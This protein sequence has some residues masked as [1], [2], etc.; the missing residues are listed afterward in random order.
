MEYRVGFVMD[1]TSQTEP[2]KSLRCRLRL[3]LDTGDGTEAE[4]DLDLEEWLRGPFDPAAQLRLPARVSGVL[5]SQLIPAFRKELWRWADERVPANTGT[6]EEE[7]VR[8]CDHNDQVISALEWIAP[9]IES[10]E[11]REWKSRMVDIFMARSAN[12]LIR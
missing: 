4:V 6:F 7:Y 10:D 2:L 3:T 1:C 12:E 5:E 11:E 9:H 8:R